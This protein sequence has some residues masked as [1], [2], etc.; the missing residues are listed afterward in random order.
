MGPSQQEGAPAMPGTIS[1][2]AI[3]VQVPQGDSYPV[4]IPYL[5]LTYPVADVGLP[6]SALQVS[7]L[8]SVP[9]NQRPEKFKAFAAAKQL[10]P[11]TW[12]LCTPPNRHDAIAI[13]AIAHD[14]RL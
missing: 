14:D 4:A 3:H 5:S 10:V 8:M 11:G 2:T 9:V 12:C 7:Q 6:S 1:T 13:Q